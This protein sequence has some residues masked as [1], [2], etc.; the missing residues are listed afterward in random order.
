MEGVNRM[1]EKATRTKWKLAFV[2]YREDQLY[3]KRKVF[4]RKGEIETYGTVLTENESLYLILKSDYNGDCMGIF[5]RL[6]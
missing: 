1:I 2:K 3:L 5:Q 4:N 6:F